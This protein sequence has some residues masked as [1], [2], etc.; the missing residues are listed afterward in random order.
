MRRTIWR[1][2][3]TLL[4][5]LLLGG[6]A[7]AAEDASS[8]ALWNQFGNGARVAWYSN[9]HVGT[10][11]PDFNRRQNGMAAYLSGYA[12][13]CNYA[14]HFGS[15]N[16]DSEGYKPMVFT[17]GQAKGVIDT[18]QWEGFREGIDDIQIFDRKAFVESLFRE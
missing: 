6:T 2:A 5:A 4:T 9:Q 3:L 16:D 11:N 14:H 17:Y 8:T 1:L 18:L 12:C 10:E 13:H 7:Q 15:Y